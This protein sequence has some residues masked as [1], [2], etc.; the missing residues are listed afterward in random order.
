M[1]GRLGS[2]GGGAQ[3]PEPGWRLLPGEVPH[4]LPF[5]SAFPPEVECGRDHGDSQ[6]RAGG[7]AG[8]GSGGAGV[9]GRDLAGAEEWVA[10]DP[11]E[12]N[13]GKGL[14][15]S[16]CRHG[17]CLHP[18]LSP[19][20]QQAQ[21]RTGGKRSSSIDVGNRAQLSGGGQQD[22]LRA[23]ECMGRCPCTHPSRASPCRTLWTV[24]RLRARCRVQGPA[25]CRQQGAA[26]LAVPRCRN[27]G[28]PCAEP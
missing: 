12:S 20:M 3:H 17:P 27:S 23:A 10:R 18:R 2:G 13:R 26:S 6:D 15:S 9:L 5:F 4:G 14:S 25:W 19:E 11:R 8:G 24:C 21:T 28:K 16:A 22:V 1:A 7:H